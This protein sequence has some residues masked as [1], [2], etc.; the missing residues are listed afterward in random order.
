M[1]MVAAFISRLT[2]QVGW[3]SMSA[4][5]HPGLSLHSSHEPSEMSQSLC[6]DFSAI[7]I[8]TINCIH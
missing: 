3:L 7:N 2:V 5:N 4:D 6:H 8:I 1:Q